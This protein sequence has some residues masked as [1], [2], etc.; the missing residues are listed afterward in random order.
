MSRNEQQSR[1]I[2]GDKG[3]VGGLCMQSWPQAIGLTTLAMDAGVDLRDKAALKKALT[4]VKLT[5]VVH[6]AGVS[7]VPDSV[8]DPRKTYEIN[9]LGTLNLLEVLQEIDFRG[10]FLF[11]SSGD[12]YGQVVEEKLP[13][14]EQTQLSPR[15]PYAVSKAAAEALCYQWSQTAKFDV[16]I[17]R[18]FNHI[19][20]GQ[21]ERF[22]ISDFA[23]QIVKMT[24]PNQEKTL[25]VGNIEVSR[26][27]LDARDVVR[28]YDAVLKLG[29]NSN[30]YNI[31]SNR[32]SLVSDLVR[33]L[34]D[35][36]GQN[37]NIEID[38]TRWRIA[39]QQRMVGS[40]AKLVEETGWKPTFDLNETLIQIYQHW[41]H[42]LEK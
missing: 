35:I 5:E 10:R 32:E 9:F 2:T 27:F 6:L 25:H 14:T 39:D 41:E 18:P 22:A 30:V 38:P 33:R 17:A 4:P 13:V 37:I 12:A 7:F 21:S 31:C 3:F 36:S 23:K 20:A 16:L 11:V 24:Q 8:S 42:K 28:A 19:G 15:N 34:I 29:K 40:N 1:L 26:D